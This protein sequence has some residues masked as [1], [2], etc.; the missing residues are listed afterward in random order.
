MRVA[1]PGGIF[2]AWKLLAAAPR[3]GISP[4]VRF[5][6]EL[7]ELASCGAIGPWPWLWYYLGVIW[8]RRFYFWFQN[9]E[10]P[11]ALTFFYTI[12]NRRFQRVVK[13][14]GFLKFESHFWNLR[15]RL[16]IGLWHG[17]MVMSPCHHP[18]ALSRRPGLKWCFG[19]KKSL[20][21]LEFQNL[22]FIF[23]I[24]DSNLP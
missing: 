11:T 9:F 10:I 2:C 5:P 23:E 20:K 7:S 16:A 15:L 3:S 14:V 18:M 17:H 22:N 8:G 24:S 1:K 21:R 6:W 4:W 13:T 19:Y 12:S